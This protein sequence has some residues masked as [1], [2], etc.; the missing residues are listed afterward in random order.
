MSGKSK[1]GSSN[2]NIHRIC[3]DIV[4]HVCT[5]CKASPPVQIRLLVA[6]T[7]LLALLVSARSALAAG[8]VQAARSPVLARVVLNDPL[9]E[10]DRGSHANIAL[11]RSADERIEAA[12]AANPNRM[13]TIEVR[14]ASM[15]FQQLDHSQQAHIEKTHHSGAAQWYETALDGFLQDIVREAGGGSRGLRLSVYGLPIE[16]SSADVV[17]TNA[18]YGGT[19]ALLDAVVSAKK[20]ITR[21]SVGEAALA[22][23]ALPQALRDANG[24]PVFYR[25]NNQWRMLTPTGHTAQDE[26]NVNSHTAQDGLRIRALETINNNAGVKSLLRERGI[27]LEFNSSDRQSMDLMALLADWGRSGSQWDL[28]H[29]GIVNVFDLMILLA[30]WE[31]DEPTTG[32]ARFINIDSVYTIGSNV[33]FSV[34]LL[35]DAPAGANVVFQT[36]SNETNSIEGPYADYTAPFNYPSAALD[37]VTPGSAEVQAL[38]RNSSNHVVLRLTQH[39]EFLEDPFDGDTDPDG[40]DPTDPNDPGDDDDE[41]DD[42][43][44]N[45]PPGDPKP[46]PGDPGPGHNPPGGDGSPPYDP[47]PDDPYT[48]ADELWNELYSGLDPTLAAQL[49]DVTFPQQPQLDNPR[50]IT[51]RSAADIPQPIGSNCIITVEG[52]IDIN[53]PDNGFNFNNNASDVILRFAPGAR[54]RYTGGESTRALIQFRSTARRI[55]VEN[56]VIVGHV[57]TISTCHAFATTYSTSGAKC[58]DITIV[59][60]DIS[61]VR[62]TFQGE[63]GCQ[64]LLIRDVNAH[65]NWEYFVWGSN[66]MTDATFVGNTINGVVGQHGFRLAPGV[67]RVNLVYND[68]QIGGPGLLKR[69]IWIPGATNVSILGNHTRDGRITIGPDPT[70]NEPGPNHVILAGNRIDH[71]RNNLA[72]ELFCGAR[73]VLV[74]DNFITTPH[75]DWMQ[76][77]QSDP[78]NRPFENIHWTQDNI[79]NGMVRPGFNGVRVSSGFIGRPDIGPQ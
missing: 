69:T 28:N 63:G 7:A 64:R 59:G 21:A 20:I 73:N 2:N 70:A 66:G 35:D 56:A 36:W 42:T 22:E 62:Y 38:I 75:A 46:G 9:I 40:D 58:Q 26:F 16:S 52:T 54:L 37:L 15:S 27:D 10:L 5:Q 60:G 76:V 34:E 11:R 3:T 55:R 13:V 1:V 4:Q 48:P 14:R 30:N 32:I 79:S 41:P 78:Y 8:P 53:S 61:G 24:R 68:I 33:S 67:D 72:I 47:T 18:R 57:G 44:P 31:H 71:E 17:A 29:D 74:S 77:G 25:A 12:H 49:Q 6:L 45:N 19:I 43:K 39:V 51:V 50:Q 65:D 23:S